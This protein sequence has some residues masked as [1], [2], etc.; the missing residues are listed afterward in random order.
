VVLDRAT[1]DGFT[2]E[3]GDQE[4]PGGRAQLVWVGGDP[5]GWIESRLRAPV[6]F[7]EVGA[8]AALSITSCRIDRLDLDHRPRDQALHGAHCRYQLCPLILV[9]R[10]KD[11]V[12]QL[13]AS[14]VDEVALVERILE[15]TVAPTPAS[16]H[17]AWR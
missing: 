17:N 12:G 16:G 15:P 13:V 14:L 2:A 6:E 5:G 3:V 11:R 8:Q 10:C 7:G 9:Q 1:A 4:R